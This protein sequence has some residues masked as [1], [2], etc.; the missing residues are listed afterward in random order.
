MSPSPLLKTI[1]P[2]SAR[3]SGGKPP[4]G[5]PGGVSACVG[6]ALGGALVP[7]GTALADGAFAGRLAGV[8]FAPHAASRM[9]KSKHSTLRDVRMLLSILV[10]D[11][12]A[13]A[14]QLLGGI[15]RTVCLVKQRRQIPRLRAG[16]GDADA[17]RHVHVA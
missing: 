11:A 10:P 8:P 2:V 6:A 1:W 7:A 9:P 12:D 15:E 13:V 14:A 3:S 17:D 4:A 5:R 16:R